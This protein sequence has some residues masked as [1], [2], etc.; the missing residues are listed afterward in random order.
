MTFDDSNFITRSS[1]RR[2]CVANANGVVS[3]VTGASI[4]SLSP[5]LKLS[6]TLLV[7]SLSHKLLSIGQ[8]IEEL[9][10]VVFIYSTFCFLQD[11]LT[12]EIIGR[13]TKKGGL[14]YVDDISTGHVFHA[15]ND[16]RERQIRLWHQRLGHPNFGN[17][18]HLLPDLFF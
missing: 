14:Y 9:N 3:L 1:P 10:C 6:H 4:M 8:V 7:P 16:G 15:T 18:K 2:T 13:G 5:S 12:K 11:M 17:L